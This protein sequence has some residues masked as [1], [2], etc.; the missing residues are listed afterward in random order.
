MNQQSG[1]SQLNH[2][3]QDSQITRTKISY[4]LYSLIEPQ[5]HSYTPACCFHFDTTAV[6]TP[7]PHPPPPH[8][9]P[10]TAPLAESAPGIRTEVTSVGCFRRGAPSLMFD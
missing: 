1:Y 2:H 6:H 5:P 4:T 7:P 9:A 10:F 3:K 8:P